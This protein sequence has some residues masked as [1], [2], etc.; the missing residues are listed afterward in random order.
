[1]F[2]S[3]RR[4]MCACNSAAI[5]RSSCERRKR[6][7]NRRKRAMASSLKNEYSGVPQHRA[8][9]FHQLVEAF[10]RKVELAP[11]GR[12]ELVVLRFPI[13]FSERPLRIDPSALLHAVQGRVQ[14]SL[15]YPQQVFGRALN[16]KHDAI[17]VQRTRSQCLQN[18]QIERSLEVVFRH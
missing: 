16:M 1:M 12:S 9:T 6:L 18:Q 5:S 17:T 3:V 10:F 14:R 2:S 11:T 13:G 8:H 7:E 4:S 15:F